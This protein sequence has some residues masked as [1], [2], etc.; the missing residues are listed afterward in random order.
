MKKLSAI[1]LVVF[2][3]VG[4]GNRELT[5]EFDY[6]SAISYILK[7]Q[8]KESIEVYNACEQILP[9]IIEKDQIEDYQK[10]INI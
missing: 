9:Q 10:V 8:K 1:L 7:N 4:C 6:D 2:I 5:Q 3:L